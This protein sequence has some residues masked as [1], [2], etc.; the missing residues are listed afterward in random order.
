MD[1]VDLY[2]IH[3]PFFP[4]ESLSLEE[5]W[6]QMEDVKAK[7]LAKEIGISNFEPVDVEKVLKIAKVKPALNQIEL[8]PYL[9]KSE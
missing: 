6:R 7:G 4:P 3:N 2:L 5:A 9:W 1:Y 8:H